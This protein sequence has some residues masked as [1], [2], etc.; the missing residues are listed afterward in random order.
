MV[1]YIETFGKNFWQL[2]SDHFIWL[3]LK[4]VPI[5]EMYPINSLAQP[6]LSIFK[7]AE[8]NAITKLVTDNQRYL[9]ELARE[10]DEMGYFLFH[11]KDEFGII[12]VEEYDN[13]RKP[14]RAT[15]FNGRKIQFGEDKKSLKATNL[16]IIHS[17]QKYPFKDVVYE[18]GEIA[19]WRRIYID[20]SLDDLGD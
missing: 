19:Y 6:A 9:N 5:T 1:D 2:G 15:I 18:R 8:W 7:L 12:G 14:G 10:H 17:S 13:G 20:D 4:A 16:K 11:D 3:P